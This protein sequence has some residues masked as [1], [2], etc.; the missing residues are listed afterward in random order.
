MLNVGIVGSEGY[1]VGELFSLL[2]NH[3]DVILRKVYAPGRAG[4]MVNDIHPGL[5]GERCM[6]FSG[7]ANFDELDILF[8]CLQTGASRAFL[9]T[10][11][12]PEYLKIIDFSLEHRLPQEGVDRGFVYGLPECYRR[13]IC[14]S[15]KVAVPG[16]FASSIAVALIPLAKHLLLNT[17]IHIHS[18]AGKTEAAARPQ[19]GAPLSYNM[20]FEDFSIY[21]PFTHP[22]IDEVHNTLNDIQ[23]S[24]QQQMNFIP[25]RGNFARGIY[26]SIY[27][28]CS[29]DIETIKEMYREYYE[30]HSFVHIVDKYPDVRDIANTNNCLIHLSKHNGKLLIVSTL[31]NLMKGAAGTAI[32]I[33]NLMA[34]LVETTGLR[35]K[36]SSY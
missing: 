15:T 19:A 16:C 24:F 10:H 4:T 36:S 6:E 9:S 1:A 30:D 34:G 22:Q 3:P 20:L 13:L 27:L 26:T 12:L 21:R 29:V 35:L 7:D 31:D 18:V 11:E 28:D 14:N 33:M 5:F 25:M 17:E 2:I 32:H 8:I 23:K